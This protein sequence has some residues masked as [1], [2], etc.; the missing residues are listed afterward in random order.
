[1]KTNSIFFVKIWSVFI[2]YSFLFCY[3]ISFAQIP[4]KKIQQ[5][6]LLSQTRQ[7]NTGVNETR[8]LSEDY[9]EKSPV[10]YQLSAE[11]RSSETGISPME[12][13]RTKNEDVSKRDAFS[14]H[15][16]NADGSYTALIGA[17]PLHYKKNGRWENIDTKVNKE[18]IGNYAYSNKTNLMESYFGA[19]S[20]K[21]VLSKTNEGEVKEFLNTKMYWES[22]GQKSGEINSADVS[23]KIN[24]DKLF[25]DKL[26]GNISAEYTVL[27]GKRKLNYVIPNK[28]ALADIPTNADYLVFSEDLLLPNGWT[29]TINGKGDLEIRNVQNKT[30][31]IYAKPTVSDNYGSEQ[32]SLSDRD[33]AEFKVE[34]NGQ[35]LTYVL[36]VKTSWLLNGSRVFPLAID[37]TVYPDSALGWTGWATASG[38][39]NDDVIAGY[40]SDGYSMAGFMRF[41]LSGIPDNS[42][43]TSVSSNLYY[44][45]RTGF[46]NGRRMAITDINADPLTTPFYADIW[47]SLSQYISLDYVTWNNSNQNNPSWKA[48]NFSTEGVAYV[49]DAL[50][51]D[52]VTV[53]AYPYQANTWAVDNY[54]WFAGYSS[55]N[56]PQLII[57]YNAVPVCNTPSSTSNTYFISNVTF[58]P[59]LI[60][61]TTSGNTGYAVSGYSN[62]A[63][64][65]ATQIPGGVINVEVSNNAV[66]NFTKAWVD[67]DKNGVFDSTEKVYDSGSIRAPN[68]IFGFVVPIGTAPG[69]YKIRIRNFQNSPYYLACGVLANGETEEYTFT[70]IADCAAKI[71]SVSVPQT[72]GAGPVSLTATGVS[73]A[74]YQWYSS[75]FGASAIAG[76]TGATYTTPSLGVG[77]Y[78]Y[79]VTAKSSSGCE[80]VYRTPVKVVVSPVPVIQFTQT[81]PD[82]C[83][84]VSSLAVTSSGDKEEVTLFSDPFNNMNNF[85]NIVAGNNNVNAYWQVR[86]SPYVPTSPPYNVNKP[87]LS[88]GFTGGNFV[89]INTDVRQ[90]TSVIN[91]LQMK[92]NLNSI[93]YQNLKADFDLYYFSIID[94]NNTQG[95]VLV[96]YSINGGGAWTTLATY[97]TDQGISPSKWDTKTISLP[98]AVLNQTQLKL[99]F[100]TMAYGGTSGSSTLWVGNIVAIDNLRIY[101]D[102]PLNTTFS[103]TGSNVSIFDADCVTPYSGASTTV[104]V[105]PT[106]TE[107]ENNAIFTVNA[108]ATL[109]N[110][111]SAV[112]TF[113]V[114][115]N[116]KT[117]DTASTNWNTMNWKPGTSVPDATKCV[118]IKTPVNIPVSN[119][120]LAKNVTV[121]SGGKLEIAGN[122]TVTDFIKNETGD[123]DNF[124]VKSDGNLVQINAVTNT[125]PIRAD[126]YVTDM[127][128]VLATQMDYVYWSAPVTG[129]KLRG[130]AAEGGFSPGTPDNRFFEYNESTDYFVSTPD[131][132]FTPGKGYAIRAEVDALHPAN[133][134]GYTET[135]RFRG[136]PNNGD[137]PVNITRSLDTGAV[138]HGYNLVGNPYPS[139]ISFDRLYA[140]NPGLIYNTVWLWTNA[141]YT[142]T[143]QGSG[144]A[145]NN[146]A[147]YNGSGGNNATT[148]VAIPAPDGIIKV[149][150]GFLVQK[151]TVGTGQLLFKNSYGTGQDL[152]VTDAGTFY[153]KGAEIKNRFTLTLTSPAQVLNSQLIAYVN[154]ATNGYEQDYDAEIMGVSS[155]LFYSVLG[156]RRLLIQGK[157]VFTDG[158]AVPLGANFFTDGDYTVSLNNAEGIFAGAQSVYLKDKQTGIITDLSAGSYSFTAA[159]GISDGRF[160]VIYKP[161]TILSTDGT[162]KDD[163]TV[164]RDGDDF[165]IRSSG[166]KITGVELYD[167]AGRLLYHSR[168]N[169]TATRIEGAELNEGVYVLKIERG[170]LVSSKKIMK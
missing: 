12:Q 147:V 165:V 124:V 42:L 56:K 99:R 40:Y 105:K 149:G 146:Y 18:T 121:Q 90:N 4:E 57:N 17:G 166:A 127:D 98:A 2:F 161:E 138:V 50:S 45:G 58:K 150:Q 89:M 20:A 73:A 19:T 110:G 83:G 31:F 86:P 47:S 33:A 102:K 107:L 88:S 51:K 28:E 128:N 126:R 72:C 9:N 37:P 60:G 62:S 92:N 114:P 43:V 93:G 123:A 38:G 95:Y 70:V 144:Y 111:C 112:G 30:T 96:E 168:L 158:D 66:S 74:S 164:Y 11:N 13:L 68:L 131:A 130:T 22:D 101:G 119:S 67:W 155:D 34:Q 109:S 115:N 79:Y 8:V 163:L 32:L 94:N 143:Q 21:G 1:M 15:Y 142:L 25:Y 49:Q 75:E 118:I 82:I 7:L 135:Y 97:L 162:Q 77:N 104:C 134:A 136:I 152:R 125:D 64:N 44:N 145:G 29:Y 148:T 24:G 80:S 139:N 63:T 54:A 6:D 76:A 81:S 53:A 122:L 41:N 84:S 65:M 108:T 151:R 3:S 117:W 132:F 14:K 137:I 35:Y 26:Y 170:A 59:S 153:Q 157:G 103:W 27:I 160:E 69:T 52:F 55:P 91:R 140:G 78:T 16:K 169:Q 10:P 46:L 48:N 159:K 133:A 141:T 39:N 154:G 87:A 85:D 23:A 120:G 129:Q 106:A 116:S 156:D 113:T 167:G 36:K 5:A 71:T 61:Q 100:T